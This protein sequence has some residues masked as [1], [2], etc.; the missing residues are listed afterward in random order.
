MSNIRFHTHVYF[1]PLTMAQR[2]DRGIAGGE[3]ICPAASVVAAMASHIGDSV[4]G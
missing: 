2:I 4:C 3:G 1:Y